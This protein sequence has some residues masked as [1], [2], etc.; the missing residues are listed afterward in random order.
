MGLLRIIYMMGVGFMVVGV[1][2]E[3][4]LELRYII[5]VEI[6]EVLRKFVYLKIE[7]KDNDWDWG[8]GERFFI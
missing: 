6:T 8:G 2:Y 3:C 4:Q 5:E 7:I 1:G